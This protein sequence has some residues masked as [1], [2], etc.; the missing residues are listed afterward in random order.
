MAEHKITEVVIIYNPNST[1]DSVQNAKKL[2]DELKDRSYDKKVRLVPTKHSKHAEELARSYAKKDKRVLLISSSGDGG[3]HELINGILQSDTKN[4]I[5]GLLPSGNANDHF[6][7]IGSDSVADDIVKESSH[8]IDALMIESTSDGKPWTRYAHSYIGIGISPV[9]SKELNK[10]KLNVFNEKIILIRQL[11]SFDY[12][13]IETGGRKRRI[14]SLIFANI[15][16][17]SKV[18]KLAK[19]GSVNDG[20]FEVNSIEAGTK[21][22]IL[23]RIFQASTLGLA[24]DESTA[25][26][27]FKTIQRTAIQLDGEVYTLD[28]HSDVKV[29]IVPKALTIII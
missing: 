10:T 5:V 12:V 26:Y 11:F 29:S 23:M 14:T 4:S 19:K 7:A 18:L 15:Q 9:V 21:L 6:S 2:R 8:K 28:A 13:R 3:Y 20:K 17:M 1:G 27:Q 16:T 25:E 24:E 22:Q